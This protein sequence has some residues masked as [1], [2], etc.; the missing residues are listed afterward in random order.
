M[1]RCFYEKNIVLYSGQYGNASENS[2]DNEHYVSEVKGQALESA[3][4][5]KLIF[6]FN[7]D[8]RGNLLSK[9]HFKSFSFEVKHH[10]E[11]ASNITC[12]F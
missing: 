6:S 7:W 9:M 4:A 2:I 10:E 8:Y 1:H 3:R 12:K 11:T 5:T